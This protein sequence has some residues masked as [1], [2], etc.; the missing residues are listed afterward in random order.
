MRQGKGCTKRKGEKRGKEKGVQKGKEKKGGK[1]R[2]GK[3]RKI[4]DYVNYK[5]DY[6]LKVSFTIYILKSFQRLI[7]I[8]LTIINCNSL[9]RF[10]EKVV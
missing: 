7:A 1:K 4:H 9:T 10:E 3:R 6:N 8:S 2:K 5:R